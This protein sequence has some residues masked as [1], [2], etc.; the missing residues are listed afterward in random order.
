MDFD[1]KIEGA[2]EVA[3]LLKTAPKRIVAQSYARGLKAA[4]NVLQAELEPL[5]PR[6]DREPHLAD[7]VVVE[8]AL[9]ADYSGGYAH[10]GFGKLGYRAN[11]VEYGHRMVTHKPDKEE[12]GTVEP[13][14][15]MR[16]ALAAASEAMIEIFADTVMEQLK[17]DPLNNV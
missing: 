12:V 4:A 7:S 2:E 17:G 1:I 13:K 15:F 8:V 16:P 3:E 11:F 6:G 10:I 5:I 9:N 14:P